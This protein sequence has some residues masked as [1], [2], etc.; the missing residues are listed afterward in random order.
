ML[1]ADEQ[2]V[3]DE[4]VNKTLPTHE[5]QRNRCILDLCR[6]LKAIPLLADRPA[7]DLRAIIQDWHA[8]AHAVIGTKPFE[9]TWAD[10]VY[11]W[12]RV[13]WP[14]GV[15]LGAAAQKAIDDTETPP[16]ARNYEDPKTQ[17]LLRICWQ[18]QQ[19]QG[20]QPFYLSLRTAGELVGLSH[21]ESGKRLEMFMEDGLLAIALAHTNIRATRY[22][23]LDR[24][25]EGGTKCQ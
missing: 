22:R 24:D 2:Q 12:K 18:L 5:G 16:E 10:F 13:R 25:K 20:S 4:V 6:R 17:L 11:T 1:S 21:T 23:F 9:K 8:R 3:I 7:R 15:Q 19:S 14:H